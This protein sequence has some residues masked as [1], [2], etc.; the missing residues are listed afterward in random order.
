MVVRA[1]VG[2]CR[3]V[4]VLSRSR[5]ARSPGASSVG[6]CWPIWCRSTRCTPCCSRTQACPMRRSRRCS[7]CGPRS[8]SWPRS[9]PG[10]SRTASA[11]APRSSSA[12]SC[13][14][15][16]MRPGSCSPSFPASRRASCCG[17]WAAPSPRVRRRRCC[18][19]GWSQ[20]VPRSTTPGS[21]AGSARQG[22]SC[23]CR[24]PGSR[25]RCSSPAVIPRPGGR[26]WRRASVPPSW[27]LGFR[28][29]PGTGLRRPSHR[30]TARRTRRTWR[31]SGKE[32]RTSSRGR[33]YSARCWRSACS[34]G[35]TRSRSTSRWWP[36]TYGCPPRWCPWRCSPCRS[37]A[38]WGPPSEARRT[39]S[40]PERSPSCWLPVPS[41]SR[42]RR[43]CRTRRP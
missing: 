28:R 38:Q 36:A 19:T 22:W 35:W 40:V 4:D 2:S 27:P 42:R 6:R 32:W 43:R 3:S 1:T 21:R 7:P 30:K 16:A 14:R 33:R 39:D 37:S 11:A 41:S 34:T 23:R 20:P 15:S 10:R 25:P 8:G 13:R 9:P 12:P 17:D 24:R 29:N 26:A 31:P 5:P 18:T